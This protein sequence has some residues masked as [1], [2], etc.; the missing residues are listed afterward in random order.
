M[1]E[2]S[3][4]WP[5]DHLVLRKAVRL[6]NSWARVKD[7]N[8]DV[9]EIKGIIGVIQMG[10]WKSRLVTS[11]A[12]AGLVASCAAVPQTSGPLSPPIIP[13]IEGPADGSAVESV[14]FSSSGHEGIDEWRED[15][16]ARMIEKGHAPSLVKALLSDLKPISMWLGNDFQASAT[17]IGDQAEF[18]KPIWDYLKVPLGNTRITTGGKKLSADPVMFDTLEARYGVDREVLAAIW[19]METS[20]GS[21]IGTFNAANALANMAV[22]GRRQSFAEGE[23]MA[24]AKIVERGD[25]TAK[26]LIAGWAGAMGQTQFMPTTYLSYAADFEGDGRIDVWGNEA[27]ALASAANYLSKSGYIAGQPWGMEVKVPSNF[28]YALGDGKERRVTTWEAAGLVPIAGGVFETG[29]ADFAELWLPAGAEGPKYLL[30][31]NFSVFKKYNRS[32]SYAFAVGMVAQTLGGEAG[33]VTAWPTHLK[34]LSV[35]NIK[36]LQAGL[37]KRGFDAGPV[38]GI[39]GRRTK[40]ALQKFQASQSVVADGYPTLEMLQLLGAAAASPS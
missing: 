29:G 37:N 24:L 35:A 40:S 2:L 17:G 16:S 31:H 19:G 13:P 21:Y 30:F 18:A 22:E 8:C 6:M 15:F 33:P 32:D 25:A 39:P 34:P 4:A 23:L 9:R 20:Y 7:T 1:S 10:L 12:L 28:N 36:L 3:W 38:D 26:D 5:D 27:D 11:V 14:S